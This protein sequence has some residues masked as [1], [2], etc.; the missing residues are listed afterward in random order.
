VL[1]SIKQPPKENKMPEEKKLT[2]GDLVAGDAALARYMGTNDR[3]N[4]ELGMSVRKHVKLAYGLAR[5]AQILRPYLEAMQDA[6][7]PSEAL[8][9]F[10]KAKQALQQRP[11]KDKTLQEAL[12]E[13]DAAN[14]PALDEHFAIQ[15]RNIELMKEVVSDLPKF[16]KISLKH[17][18]GW[19]TGEG[20]LLAGDLLTFM[21]LG[22]LCDPEDP[23]APAVAPN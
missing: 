16:Y 9:A 13:L 4:P 15:E 19:E 22:I 12:T 7:K 6:L 18:P 17:V 3:V 10:Y 21:Q 2:N 20:V 23:P 1:S 8:Q 5:N 11:E 14:V